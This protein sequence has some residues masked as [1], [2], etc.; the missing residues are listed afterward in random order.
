[1]WGHKKGYS[2]PLKLVYSILGV[3]MERMLIYYH[4]LYMEGPCPKVRIVCRFMDHRLEKGNI[5]GY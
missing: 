5:S 3:E 2:Q 1:M 4:P